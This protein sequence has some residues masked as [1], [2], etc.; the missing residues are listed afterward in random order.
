MYRGVIPSL[1]AC[2]KLTAFRGFPWRRTITSATD[3]Y[4]LEKN[5]LPSTASASSTPFPQCIVFDEAGSYEKVNAVVE[6]SRLI[7][8]RDLLPRDLRKIDKGYDDIVPSVLVRDASILIS[9][10]HVRA[11]IKADQ[12]VLFNYDHS[13]STK[14]FIRALSDKLKNDGDEKL[15]Y[16]VR[17]LEAIFSDVI[18][19]LNTEMKAHMD[20]ANGILK[21][22]EDEIDLAKLKYLLIVAKKLQQFQQR[23]TLIRDIIDELL[24]QDDELAELYLTEK[25][26]GLPRSAHDHQEVEL[27]LESYA[28]H[29]DA[30]VQTVDNAISD[31]KTTEE[32]INIILDSNRNDLMLLGLQFSIALMCFGS[33]LFPAAVYG[34]NL[35]NF[36]E[37]HDLVFGI[38]VVSSFLI[39][40]GFFRGA[41]ARL[42]KL[43]KVQLIKQKV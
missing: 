19:N 3:S 33:L 29:C 39:T 12:V 32:I 21:E 17:A 8:K 38:V 2:G 10:L 30:I 16:E 5:L 34:M 15:H 26:K 41:L 43:K 9:I 6:R 20:V 37:E 40:Y 28:L 11:M 4:V 36:F 22:L 24:D 1:R 23:A 27:L 42:S 18:D 7:K 13:Y 35:Q 14:K 25:E 31:V